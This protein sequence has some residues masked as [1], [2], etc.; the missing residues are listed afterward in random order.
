HN[1]DHRF[2]GSVTL[3]RAL[4]ESRNIPAVKLAQKVGMPVVAEYARRF[5]ITSPIPPY[6]P[7]AL[8]A[9]D[10]TLFEQTAAFTVFPNDGILIEPRFI[11]KVTDYE[12][13]VLEDDYPD[14][15]DVISA[16]T[17]RTMVSLLQGVV[18]NGTA[19]M[20]RRLKHPLGGKTGTTNDYTDAWFI[21][22]SPSITCGVWIGYDEK[23]TLGEDETG[24]HAALPVWIDFMR[25]ALSSPARR[26]ESFP[27]P[28]REMRKTAVAT[29][30]AIALAGRSG[31][32][33]A[34]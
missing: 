23:K 3:R 24:G 18:Q 29:K 15:R 13:H 12:G 9:A 34:R 8:G 6:L 30:P 25:V 19:A 11:R 16:R 33:E 7:V 31:N 1:F 26:Q 32:A 14:A 28:F 2:A 20:A 21:G 10:V 17:A 5:G 4:A 27:P 22:F